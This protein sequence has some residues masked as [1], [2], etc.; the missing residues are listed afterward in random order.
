[1]NL[2]YLTPFLS[3]LCIY[4][5]VGEKILP[6]TFIGLLFIISGILLQQWKEMR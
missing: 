2:I 4:F 3:M 1:S 6:S 5:F